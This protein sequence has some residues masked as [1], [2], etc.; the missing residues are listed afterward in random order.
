MCTRIES[1]L[2]HPFLTP[3]HP[4]DG[5]GILMANGVIQL[6]LICQFSTALITGLRLI[7]NIIIVLV[8]DQAVFRINQNPAKPR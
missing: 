5:A 4:D 1:T 2:N 8:G 7:T 6:E 3:G